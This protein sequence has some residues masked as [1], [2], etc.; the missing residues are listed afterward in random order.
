MYTYMKIRIYIY[1]NMFVHI[2]MRVDHRFSFS[3]CSSNASTTLRSTQLL[4]SIGT[5]PYV[6]PPPPIISSLPKKVKIMRPVSFLASLL[7]GIAL[8][9]VSVDVTDGLREDV[10]GCEASKLH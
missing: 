6:F 1:M 5:K 8:G 4:S 9:D 7:V 2:L 10:R 3:F